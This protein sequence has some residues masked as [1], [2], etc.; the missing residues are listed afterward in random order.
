MPPTNP[1]ISLRQIKPG[2]PSDRYWRLPNYIL[3]SQVSEIRQHLKAHN[4]PHTVPSSDFP[5][6]LQSLARSLP[7]YERCKTAELRLFARQR[8]LTDITDIDIAT[9]TRQDLAKAL[10]LADQNPSFHR[11][12]E[13]PSELR[14]SIY[15]F[16][17]ASF[18]DEPL[19]LPTYPPL[20]R[21]N[22]QL[23]EEVLPVFYSS[24]TFAVNL[25][26]DVHEYFQ[27]IT[28][29]GSAAGLLAPAPGAIPHVLRMQRETTL[30]FK[31]LSS[32]HIAN[33]QSLEVTFDSRHPG[34]S[35]ETFKLR[36]LIPRR[37]R[38]GTVEVVVHKLWQDHFGDC[39]ILHPWVSGREVGIEKLRELEGT[40]EGFVEG[41]QK[42]GK[43]ENCLVV[44]D[45]YHLRAMLETF[46]EE[47]CGSQE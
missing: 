17:C 47:Q 31:A 11:F 33:I 2:H 14:T 18:A 5:S 29:T 38:K 16:Y 7:G 44:A 39:G 20:A 30:F 4:Y 28:G 9:A 12:L 25:T 13:L 22:R 1:P 37:G 15:T 21:T 45:V 46:F 34:V 27:P 40:V 10:R 24:C 32:E 35:A 8:R 42:R 43:G 26:T 23:L 41:V 19:T 36:I 6:L 3:T